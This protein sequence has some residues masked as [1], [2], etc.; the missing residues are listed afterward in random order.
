MIN[1]SLGIDH[2][3]YCM[4]YLRTKQKSWHIVRRK[5]QR[6][7]Q[8][9]KCQIEPPLPCMNFCTQPEKVDIVW[10]HLKCL[11]KIT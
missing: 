6:A 10:G 2:L 7:I 8:I 4:P 1:I 3:A 9:V 11:V 5:T